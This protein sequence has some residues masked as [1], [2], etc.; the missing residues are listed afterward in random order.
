MVDYVNP[1][2]CHHFDTKINK[3]KTTTE[4]SATF[5][6]LRRWLK[7]SSR[8]SA[9]GQINTSSELSEGILEQSC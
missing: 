2:P 6:P 4:N 5:F 7:C 1:F 3:V 9:F 8:W